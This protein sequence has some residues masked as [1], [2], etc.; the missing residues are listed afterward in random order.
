MHAERASQSRAIEAIPDLDYASAVATGT[1]GA[2]DSYP[3]N[4]AEHNRSAAGETVGN[5]EQQPTGATNPDSDD[6][7]PFPAEIFDGLLA[8]LADALDSKSAAPPASPTQNQLEV[9]G[10][11][12]GAN[13]E[14]NTSARGETLGNVQKQV[15]A[16]VD[17]LRVTWSQIPA[18]A[19][20][21]L[22][23]RLV[24]ARARRSRLR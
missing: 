4:G 13:G 1:D 5:S 20:A 14:R 8:E 10:S 9:E 22:V 12:A 18:S 24:A 15:G 23:D 21:A 19:R 11:A 2:P 3:I 6:K 17:G 7:T 16:I